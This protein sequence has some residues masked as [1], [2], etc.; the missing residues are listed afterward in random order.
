MSES[1]ATQ[2]I[3]QAD[4]GKR[5][6]TGSGKGAEKPLAG[7]WTEEEPYIAA[8]S[9]VDAVNTAL[10]LRRPLLL[11]GEPGGGKTRLAF[12]VAYELGYPLH[13]CYIRST[14]RAQ[15]LLYEYDALG[16]LYDIQEE[17]A[18]SGSAKPRKEYV[19]YGELGKAIKRST[20]E[21]SP[22]VVLIDEIDKADIDFPNDLLLELDRLKFQVKEV[23]EIEGINAFKPTGSSTEQTREQRRHHLPL[24]IITSNR[25][26]EL[27]KPFLRRCLFYYINFPD[28]RTLKT[29]LENRF[30]DPP[31]GSL[32]LFQNIFL[33]L[34]RPELNL[35]KTPGI[36]EFLDWVT[37]LLQK[38]QGAKIKALQSLTS[39]SKEQQL[40]AFAQI[41][42]L[43]ALIKTQSDRDTLF[44]ISRGS[45]S[46]NG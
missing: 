26:K 14:S 29:I 24:I 20:E 10:Y 37:I 31:E 39:Q 3:A 15:D 23:P 12:A 30:I 17:K 44:R 11:E 40:K 9:L 13:E 27:P 1:K 16:R 34:R 32:A 5:V 7:A 45:G 2:S 36:S 8:P 38:G 6:Y 22:S 46:T 28:D 4:L 21:N 33:E 43:E 19:N 18:G 42:H 41:P 25:E 35:R